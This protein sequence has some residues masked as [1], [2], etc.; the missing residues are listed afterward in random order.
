MQTIGSRWFTH[1]AGRFREQ[2]D[3][4]RLA[5]NYTAFPI[6]GLATELAKNCDFAEPVHSAQATKEFE[7]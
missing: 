5:L 2:E 3:F 7:M 6:P 1:T 4:L